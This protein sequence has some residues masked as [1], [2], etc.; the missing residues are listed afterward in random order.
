MIDISINKGVN[1]ALVEEKRPHIYTALKYWGKNHIIFGLNTLKLILQKMG[2]DLIHLWEVELLFF[3]AIRLNRKVIGFD[4][5]PLSSFI[6]EVLTS[7]FD[8]KI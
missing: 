7:N 1:H 3:E 5:N 4:L 6:A 8:K 2:F